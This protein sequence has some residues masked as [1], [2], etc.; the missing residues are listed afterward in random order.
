MGVRR[1]KAALSLPHVLI[2]LPHGAAKPVQPSEKR[3][4]QDATAGPPE[5][6]VDVAFLRA[7]AFE[8]GI[9][10]GPRGPAAA[11]DAKPLHHD[12]RIASA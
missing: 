3:Q 10:S 9:E 6:F 2:P 7:K 5:L 8:P 12:L 4:A 11:K 1:D